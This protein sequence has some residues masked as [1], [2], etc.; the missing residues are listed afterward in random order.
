MLTAS[1][2]REIFKSRSCKLSNV[3]SRF[4]APFVVRTV[5]SLVLEKSASFVFLRSTSCSFKASRLASATALSERQLFNLTVAVFS[6]SWVVFN[7]FWAAN[8]SLLGP[9]E[10]IVSR[11][12]N[13]I[14]NIFFILYC[15]LIMLGKTIK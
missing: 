2:K 7:S 13:P 6:K 12:I 9:Q 4:S 14:T 8:N 15:F 3:F 5:I 1:C 11:E 10:V